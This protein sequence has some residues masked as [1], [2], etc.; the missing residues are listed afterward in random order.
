MTQL[1]SLMKVKKDEK[2][3]SSKSH[4]K[5]EKKKSSRIRQIWLLFFGE[6]MYIWNYR[7]EG[8]LII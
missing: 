7:K 4:P 8:L 2:K 1:R 5:R 3:K 6:T